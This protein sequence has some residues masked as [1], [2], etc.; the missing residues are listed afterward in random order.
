MHRSVHPPQPCRPTLTHLRVSSKAR[1]RR[2]QPAVRAAGTDSQPGSSGQSETPDAAQRIASSDAGS[3]ERPVVPKGMQAS[4]HCPQTRP[5]QRP[6][7]VQA[8]V[9][10]TAHGGTTRTNLSLRTLSIVTGFAT[11]IA[12]VRLLPFCN[13]AGNR[14]HHLTCQA[15]TL[16]HYAA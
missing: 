10:H 5:L 11:V 13:A 14:T 7:R 8:T 9:R 4:L 16:M 6:C 3:R 1:H 15:S 2:S 12:T